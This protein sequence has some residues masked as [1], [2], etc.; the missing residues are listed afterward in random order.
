M[1]NGPFQGHHKEIGVSIVFQTSVLSLGFAL[2]EYYWK[3]EGISYAFF[4]HK[5]IVIL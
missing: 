5:K 1:T 2:G 4:S 3:M